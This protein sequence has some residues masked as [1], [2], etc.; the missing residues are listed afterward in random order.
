MGLRKTEVACAAGALFVLQI[1]VSCGLGTDLDSYASGRRSGEPDDAQ[2]DGSSGQDSADASQNAPEAT[3]DSAA[4][5]A[6]VDA[7][8]E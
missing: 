7:D 2:P 6:E 5:S 3:D 1:A 4:D 8:L